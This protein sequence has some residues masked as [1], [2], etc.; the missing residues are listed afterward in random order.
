MGSVREVISRTLKVME[1]D[2]ILEVR[3]KEFLIRDIA[4]LQ[5]AV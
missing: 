4:A 3:R 2:G 5:A 1:E